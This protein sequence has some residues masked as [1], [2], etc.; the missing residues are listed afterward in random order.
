MP[1][2]KGGLVPPLDE[3]K[4]DGD[5]RA[6]EADCDDQLDGLDEQRDEENVQAKAEEQH[7]NG[8]GQLGTGTSI[9]WSRS[10]LSV[11]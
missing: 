2:Q 9:E 5:A 1:V 11:L 3:H 4:I 7:R 6:D 10:P 8:Q